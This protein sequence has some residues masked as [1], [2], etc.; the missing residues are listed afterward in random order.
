ML[1]DADC[2]NASC[3]PDRKQ[4]RFYDTGGLYLQVSPAG[5]KRWFLKYR[6]QGKEKQL[7]LGSYP[8]ISLKAARIARDA[9]KAEKAAGVDPVLARQQEKMR[10]SL[11]ADNSFKSVALEWYEKQKPHWS[12]SH[13]TRTFSWLERDLFPFFGNRAMDSIAAPDLLTALHRIE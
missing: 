3:P 9:A 11:T 5:S 12:A 10:Q 6:V 2:K 1:T 8:V 13:A 4:K 7:A